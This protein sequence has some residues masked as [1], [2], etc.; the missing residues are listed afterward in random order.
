MLS[1]IDSIFDGA[2]FLTEANLIIFASGRRKE[3]KTMELKIYDDIVPA[4]DQQ[5]REFCL[6]SRG[7]SFADIDEF[8]ASIPADDNDID[9]LIH[10]CGGSVSEGWAIIDKLRATGKTISATIDG[11]C[12]SMA[13]SLYLAA[14]VRKAQPH[15]TIHIH[16]PYIPGEA[17]M[18]QGLNA[19]A[20]DDLAKDMRA[21]SDKMAAWYA[22]RTGTDIATIKAIMDEDRDMAMDEA[23]S[24]GFVHEILPAL[25][26]STRKPNYK[27][28]NMSKETKAGVISALAN[29]L[30]LKVA[31]EEPAAQ[32][33]VLMTADGSELTVERNDGEDIE[34]GDAASPD[35]EHTLEDGTVVV[36]SGGV[37]TEIREADEPDGEETEE[38]PD[39]EG[40]CGDKER[41][42]LEDRI[43]ELEAENAELKEKQKTDEEAKILSKVSKAG[44]LAWLDKVSKS[45][46]TPA[47]RVVVSASVEKVSAT[48]ARLE[49]LRKKQGGQK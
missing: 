3:R 40:K 6:M 21:E 7:I 41:K 18:A 42:A 22:E 19:D 12:A 8:I 5:A 17:F 35:G 16:N 28:I 23:V 11:T 30:G 37:I 36:V 32:A 26:A 43:A 33:L 15:A 31:V 29:F 38:T 45:S 46:Y 20:L 13:V 25:S 48:K 24:L 4:Q 1:R 49:E 44:G 39:E 27:T 34:V 10:S 47:K 14:S 9:M 2:D